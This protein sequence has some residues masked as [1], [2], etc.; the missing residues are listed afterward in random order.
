[1]GGVTF[2]VVALLVGFGILVEGKR[3]WGWAIMSVGLVTLVAVFTYFDV[4][5]G[6]AIAPGITAR[7]LV[8]PRG[9]FEDA[10][11]DLA[12]GGLETLRA[13][14]EREGLKFLHYPERR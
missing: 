9:S 12:A 4:A 8:W 7:G 5:F 3:L 11:R 14:A 10:K 6:R 1:M 13:R 2:G